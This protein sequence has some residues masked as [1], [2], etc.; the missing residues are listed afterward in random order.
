MSDLR[1]GPGRGQVAGRSDAGHITSRKR[2]Y[3]L[4][5][6]AAETGRVSTQAI[7]MLRATPQRT[8]DTRFDAPTPMM[9]DEMTC[10]VL[11]GAFS[12]VASRITIAAALSAAN[13]LIG[14]NL[15]IRWPIVFMMRHPP[16]AV[17]RAIAVAHATMAQTGT[18]SSAFSPSEAA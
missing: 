14:R 18:T 5:A 15:M 3:T 8:A 7:I 13:P 6:T 10:V 17:P 1:H 16:D 12:H 11:T 4:A 2:A 9:L